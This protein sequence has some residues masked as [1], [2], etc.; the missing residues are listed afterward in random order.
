MHFSAFLGHL[1]GARVTHDAY[2]RPQKSKR[3]NSKRSTCGS[4]GIRRI[5]AECEANLLGKRF[6]ALPPILLP[7]C[8]LCRTFRAVG[9]RGGNMA[10]ASFA[11]VGHFKQVAAFREHLA[12]LGL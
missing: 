8:W 4:M 7:G 12:S 5:S 9:A 2:A 1:R 11:K 10:D 3:S 6:H